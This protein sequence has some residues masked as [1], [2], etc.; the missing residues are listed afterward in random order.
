MRPPA[1]L[2]M[3]CT[4][5][6]VALLWDRRFKATSPH[7]LNDPFE[8][9]PPI[10]GRAS[11]ARLL[12]HF[13]Q[14]HELRETYSILKPAMSYEEYTKW[15]EQNGKANAEALHKRQENVRA[16][17]KEKFRVIREDLKVICLSADPTGVLSWALYA[18]KHRG[19]VIGID[20]SE[21]EPSGL[22]KVRYSKKRPSIN[23]KTALDASPAKME[24][25]WRRAFCTKSLEW[26]HECEFR[27]I[28]RSKWAKRG[29]DS[30]GNEVY[31]KPFKPSMIREVIFGSRC[32][33]EDV[34]RNALLDPDFRNVALLRARL[35]N[36]NFEIHIEPCVV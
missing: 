1:T 25:L 33:K 23:I 5:K 30:D 7:Q 24:E 9:D 28:F 12:K 13:S 16:N 3:Y 19:F 8:F 14:E 36:T 2:Y 15:Y 11:K 32:S 20:S 31:Y 34:I 35:D 18:D 29:A 21:I 10:I 26:K 6:A 27:C 4:P 22:T 17:A